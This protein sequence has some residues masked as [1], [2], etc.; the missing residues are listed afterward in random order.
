MDE[1]FIITFQDHTQKSGA[2]R[3]T[4]T[5]GD[6]MSVS[7][8]THVS[9]HVFTDVNQIEYNNYATF[10]TLALPTNR[11]S[12]RLKKHDPSLEEQIEYFKNNFNNIVFPN[13]QTFVFMYSLEF[14][15]DMAN[16]HAHGLIHEAASI[17]EINRFKKELRKIF[18]IPPANRIAI[19]YYKT[20][21]QNIIN[22]YQYHIG[23]IDYKQQ[24]KN[25]VGSHYYTV[26]REAN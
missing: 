4:V 1:K 5:L 2:N 13:K 11:W 12:N 21:S 23:N 22:K 10:F 16:I 15:E 19:K 7:P 6:S 3:D 18:K 26:K 14:N 8:H 9:E 24:L 17:A 25:K 20:E